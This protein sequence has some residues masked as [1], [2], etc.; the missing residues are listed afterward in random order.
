MYFSFWILCALVAYRVTA[1][2]QLQW[3]EAVLYS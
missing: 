2:M 3:Q 1:D